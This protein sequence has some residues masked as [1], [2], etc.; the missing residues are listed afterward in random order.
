MIIEV[1]SNEEDLILIALGQLLQRNLIKLYSPN[2][3]DIEHKNLEQEI[4]ELKNLISK[5]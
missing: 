1:N 5:I 2:L 4:T 3:G